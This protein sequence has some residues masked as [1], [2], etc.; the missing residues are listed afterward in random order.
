MPPEENPTPEAE[1]AAAAAAAAEAA[2]EKEKCEAKAALTKA[3]TD[4]TTVKQLSS[5]G[6]EAQKKRKK[7]QGRGS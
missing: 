6:Y 3:L 1:E 2:E 4:E 7:S 5:S